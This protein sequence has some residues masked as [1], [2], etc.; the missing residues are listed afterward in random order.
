MHNHPAA[1]PR[2]RARSHRPL[3]NRL[4]PRPATALPPCR[5]FPL[6]TAFGTAGAQAQQPITVTHHQPAGAFPNATDIQCH[7]P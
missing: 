6:K 3:A 4:S 2:H 5:N 7:N 1:A